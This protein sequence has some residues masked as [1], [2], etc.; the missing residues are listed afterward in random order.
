MPTSASTGGGDG[1][2][3]LDPDVAGPAGGSGVGAARVE[4]GVEDLG[5]GGLAPA[6][7]VGRRVLA[8]EGQELAQVPLGVGPV[9][10]LDLAREPSGKRTHAIQR[11][12]DSL[13]RRLGRL[14]VAIDRR[15]GYVG[16]G[17]VWWMRQKRPNGTA[18]SPAVLRWA[19]RDSNPRP[20]P[21]K[22]SALA[23]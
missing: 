14:D 8:P 1:V 20:L 23:T 11:W 22:G 9:H 2:R 17:Y 7:V 5:E 10:P 12:A 21:C 6:A 19:L 16:S 4:P 13:H 18:V 3:C 15:K